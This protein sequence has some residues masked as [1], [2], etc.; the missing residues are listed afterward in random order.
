MTI[1]GFDHVCI[2]VRDLDAAARGWQRLLGRE[3]PDEVYEV[4]A[5]AIRVY[6]YDLDRVG[7][8]LVA[9]TRPDGPVA[10]FI[11][12]HGEGV[13]LLALAVDD[14]AAER[15]RLEGLGLPLVGGL[16]PF[17]GGRYTFVHPSAMNG[18][19]LELVDG[20]AG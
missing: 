11:E 10:R 3:A 5:E 8:E 18:V 7:L 19:L 13:L 15:D 17:R 2:A 9:S 16:R 1:R 14:A 6:R 4:A 20:G 12:R